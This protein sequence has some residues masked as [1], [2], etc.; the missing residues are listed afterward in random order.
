[1]DNDEDDEFS[2][3]SVI[4]TV[5]GRALGAICQAASLRLYVALLQ[6][7]PCNRLPIQLSEM[8]RPL[9]ACHVRLKHDRSMALPSCAMNERYMQVQVLAGAYLDAANF[10]L[11]PAAYT[12]LLGL[13]KGFWNR[14][15]ALVSIC[16][17]CINGDT[18]STDSH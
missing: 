9:S 5:I 11:V 16:R 6:R 10:W 1:M 13:I 7:Q 4:Y 15:L 3:G 8:F 14:A 2:L 12:L 18:E 17:A